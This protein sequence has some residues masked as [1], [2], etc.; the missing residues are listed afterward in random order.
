MGLSEFIGWPLAIIAWSANIILILII[1]K[2]KFIVAS[3]YKSA[4]PV[5][6][7]LAE[8]GFTP[9]INLLG[10]HYTDKKKIDSVVCQYLFLLGQLR[11]GGIKAK[12]SVKPTQIGLA[13]SK[14]FYLDNILQIAR[15]AHNEKISLEIDVEG[16]GYLDDTLDVFMEIPGE[17]GV[18]QAVQAYLKRSRSDIGE[19]IGR[20]KKVRLVK[21][22]Y[23]ESDLKQLERQTQLINL[24]GHLMAVGREPAFA[25]VHDK[26]YIE[27]LKDFRRIEH[28]DNF[29]IQML[30]GRSND[31]KH[32]LLAEGFRVEVYM[33]VGP[34]YR[35]LPYI[36][37]RIKEIIS[38]LCS[39]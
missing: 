17:Y 38:S 27:F 34:W 4:I 36:Y 18:R 39:I 29:I 35:A 8:Q 6:K 7:R 9:I 16:L 22:A 24:T 3:D 14:E 25:T 28:K 5:A 19:M 37:R 32:E 23:S 30:Y 33:P 26:S 12:V 11:D 2:R 20:Y 10:E 21:G 31:L 1:L 13:V 15:R